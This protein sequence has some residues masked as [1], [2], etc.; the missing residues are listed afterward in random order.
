MPV[1]MVFLY[2]CVTISVICCYCFCKYSEPNL[3]SAYAA[4]Q[5]CFSPYKIPEK[6][7]LR[8]NMIR[9]FSFI[10]H[11]SESLSFFVISVLIICFYVTILSK[12]SSVFGFHA[13]AVTYL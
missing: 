9:N 11:G 10:S 3:D 1:Y 13:L 6:P 5:C 4:S 12:I 8:A 2:V 7:L